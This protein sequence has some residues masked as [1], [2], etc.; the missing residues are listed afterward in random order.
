MKKV[1]IIVDDVVRDLLPLSLLAL[2][3]RKKNILPFL[4]PSRIQ[5]FEI[6]TIK[7]EVIIINYLRKENEAIVEL[8]KKAGIDIFLLDQEGGAFKSFDFYQN[9]KISDKE[10]I[11]KLISGVF[12]WS[13]ELHKESLKREWIDKNQNILTGHPKYDIYFKSNKNTQPS[14]KNRVLLLTSF[15]LANPRL[16]SKE[17]E[18]NTWSST[19]GKRKDIEQMQS[20][21]VKSFNIY[22]NEMEKVFLENEDKIFS[23]KVHPFESPEPYLKRFNELKNVAIYSELHLHTL[24]DNHCV[25]FHISSTTSIECILENVVPINLAFLK[26]PIDIKLLNEISANC[27]TIEDF[28]NTISNLDNVLNTYSFEESRKILDDYFGTL[29]GLAAVRISEYLNSYLN[30]KKVLKDI[31][32]KYITRH[33]LEEN[34]FKKVFLILISWSNSLSKISFFNFTSQIKLWKKSIKYF[35]SAIVKSYCK[36]LNLDSNR[37]SDYKNSNSVITN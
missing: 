9:T 22:L 8:Y 26:N 7:P 30:E 5:I 3:L 15:T 35:D 24:L 17:S 25:A 1:A 27:E 12:N 4:V 2:E 13:E 23:I 28:R 20:Q 6:K 34:R 36:D 33:N 37:F 29:D 10:E 14:R 11:K 21:Q 18:V 19:G 32:Y 31:N 16:S